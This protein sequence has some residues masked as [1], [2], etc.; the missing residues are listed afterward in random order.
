MAT[1]PSASRRPAAH[2]QTARRRA[3]DQRHTVARVYSELE[4]AGASKRVVEW[5]RFVDGDRTESAA[6]KRS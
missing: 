2:R 4:R 3:E 1:E 5:A 6:A